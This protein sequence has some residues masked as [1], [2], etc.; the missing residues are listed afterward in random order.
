MIFIWSVSLVF[1][2]GDIQNKTFKNT[3]N[4]LNHEY[5]AFFGQR[6]FLRSQLHS[7]RVHWVDL[8]TASK[9]EVLP[10]VY[11]ARPSGTRANQSYQLV[12]SCWS[13]CLVVFLNMPL[14]PSNF[15]VTPTAV[16]MLCYFFQWRPP[17]KGSFDHDT[18]FF[19]HLQSKWL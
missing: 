12:H 2:C 4:T 6:G 11:F 9:H 3:N 16:K 14:T 7:T 5:W 1:H 19:L 17:E 10:D 8:F 18:I 15:E 13:C